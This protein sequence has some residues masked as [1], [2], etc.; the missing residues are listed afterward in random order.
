MPV[1]AVP[2]IDQTACAGWTEQDRSLY[3]ALPYFLAKVQV[4][5]RKTWTS[6]SKLTKK[7]KWKPNQGDTMKVIR[8]N[9]SPHIRQFAYPNV[10]ST[11]PKKDVIDIRETETDANIYRHRFES[12][13]FHFYPEFINFMSHIDEHGQDIMEKIERYEDIFIR[14]NM[15]HMSPYVFV[16]KDD[17]TVVRVNTT[18]WDGIGTFDQTNDGKTPAL[19]KELAAQ[20]TGSLSLTALYHAVMQMETDLGVPFFNGSDLPSEDQGL[21]G[22]YMFLTSSEAYHN[23]NFDPYLLQHKN[24]DLDVVQ[25]AFRGSIFGR[26]T[27]RIEDKPMRFQWEA[28]A[29]VTWHEPELRAD[30]GVTL[31]DGETIP[32]ENYTN[33]ATSQYEVGFLCGRGGYETIEVG[34]PPS[35]FAKDEMPH[36]FPKMFW[37]GEV[38]LTKQFLV[39]CLDEDTGTVTYEMNTYGEH[40][41]FISQIALGIIPLQRRNVIPILYKRKRGQ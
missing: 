11:V 21:M 12:P 10:I 16:V 8:S 3:R 34:P 22:K 17:G 36:N 13:V 5:R 9:S 4:D 38:K 29:D 2:S 20:T 23:F 28:D 35:Q 1:T 24:C 40:L 25:G 39:P 32:N 41:K 6:F 31:N 26:T 30:D 15:W 37:N 7:R 19:V 27:A 33:P 18:P 14:T